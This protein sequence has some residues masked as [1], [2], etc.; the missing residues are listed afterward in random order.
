V[1]IS[2][3]PYQRDLVAQVVEAFNTGTRT[4]VLQAATG[5]GKTTTVSE[6]IGYATARGHKTV[7]AAHLDSLIGDTHARLTNAGIRAG[8]IQA[9]RPTD[10]DA[11]VQVA[12]LA[13]L[14]ARG[15]RPTANFI[16]FDECHRIMGPTVRAIADA[17]PSAKILGLTATPQRGDGKPIGAVF[18]KLIVGPSTRWLTEQGFLVPCEVLGPSTFLDEA[19]ADDP[20]DAY[21]KHTPGRRAIVFASNVAHAMDLAAR[22]TSAGF[23]AGLIVGQTPR[24]ERER[25]RAAIT[26]GTI[27]VLVGVGVF[28]EGYDCPAIE[29]VVLARP[30][31]VTGAFLQSIGRGLRPCAETGKA[32]CTVL[33][34]RGS[35][36]LHGLPDEERRW[37]LEGTACSR[38]ETIVALR[39]CK[40]CLAIFRP[41][42]AC[43][44]CGAEHETVERIPRVLRRAERL[45]R[46]NDVSQSERDRRYIARL[47]GV[48][49]SRMRMPSHRAREWALRKF[50]AQFG[51]QPEAA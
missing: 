31:T 22:F 5:A 26:E 8:F 11:P 49:E 29:V 24:D 41:Q 15:E 9:D 7:F 28:V 45:E 19:L 20:V 18:E 27:R 12:S 2:L 38:T 30:F 40:D 51:R 34:L 39:R 21:A 37:A 47:V 4:A 14:H 35:V 44:R 46:L 42:R 6:L 16:V 13:T 36:H 23:P 1:S 10:P 43:P 50:A 25:L 17:Y 33:D 32:R 3:R 48:A